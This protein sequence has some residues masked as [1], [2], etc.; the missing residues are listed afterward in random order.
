MDAKIST[1]EYSDS[2]VQTIIAIIFGH[3]GQVRLYLCARAQLLVKKLA[4]GLRKILI[5]VFS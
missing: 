3:V 2:F 1:I 4:F 5:V